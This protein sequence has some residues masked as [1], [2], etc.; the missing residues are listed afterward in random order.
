MGADGLRIIDVRNPASPVETGFFDTD[1]N[2][3]GVYVFGS[4]AYVA[5][6]F[7]GLYIIRNDLITGISSEGDVQVPEAFVLEQNHPNPFNPTTNLRFS[8]SDLPN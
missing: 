1:D 5:D 4:Y 6:G 2:A 7:G 8:I 3:L